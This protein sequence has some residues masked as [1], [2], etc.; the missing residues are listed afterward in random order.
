[1]QF[2]F[3]AIFSIV[4]TS[5]GSNA[6]GQEVAEQSMSTA[7]VEVLGVALATVKRSVLGALAQGFV[8]EPC[9]PGSELKEKRSASDDLRLT[10]C[11]ASVYGQ[12]AG[13]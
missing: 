13:P 1:M 5:L 12:G 11:G 2:S 8:Y 10:S 7:K 4:L 6:Y 9:I 3:I